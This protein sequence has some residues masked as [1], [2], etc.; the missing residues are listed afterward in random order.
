MIKTLLRAAIADVIHAQSSTAQF[1]T[2][3]FRP[4]LL[5]RA[6]KHFGVLFRDKASSILTVAKEEAVK[7]VEEEVV[8]IS[9]QL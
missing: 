7:F 9:E 6:D 3:T 8:P 5:S 1:I 2:T 4:E